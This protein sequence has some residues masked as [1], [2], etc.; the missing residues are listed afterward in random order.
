[1]IATVLFPEGLIGLPGLRRFAWTEEGDGW[2]LLRCL[3]APVSLWAVR[4]KDVCPGYAPELDGSMLAQIGA[5]RPE[6]VVC[7]AVA[8]RSPSGHASVNLLAPLLISTTTGRAVQVVLDPD[9][10][11]LRYPLP[12][13]SA[14][15][16]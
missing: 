5:T 13:L 1:M 9:R 16:G 2:V 4:V 14:R 15:L 7:L 3:D 12:Q 6:D 8:I 10:Y 11:P